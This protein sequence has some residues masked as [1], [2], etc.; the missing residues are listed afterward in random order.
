MVNKKIF[1]FF[2]ILCS[3]VLVTCEYLIPQENWQ[4]N[5]KPPDFIEFD[6]ERFN[7]EWAAWEA[8]GITDY[9]VEEDVLMPNFRR[10]IARI[11]VRDNAI[12]QNE[13]LDRW[14]RVNV[15]DHPYYT[16]GFLNEV[17][18]ISEIYAWVNSVTGNGR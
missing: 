6:T 12:I 3:L 10:E 4:L 8:Q 5:S 9:S 14:D 2:S 13:T 7:R 18:T 17:R 1:L 16:R 15:E 11:V